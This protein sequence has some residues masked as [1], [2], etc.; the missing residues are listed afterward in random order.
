VLD[1]ER[2]EGH[3]AAV[4]S[5]AGVELDVPLAAERVLRRAVVVSLVAATQAS[6]SPSLVALGQWARFAEKVEPMTDLG[7]D[8]VVE[9]LPA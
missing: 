9:G 2:A 6:I 5:R 4:G 1:V 8:A 7:F 3:T